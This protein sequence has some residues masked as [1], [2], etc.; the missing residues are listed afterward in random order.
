MPGKR[1][2]TPALVAPLP[3]A[4]RLQLLAGSGAYT[5]AEPLAQSV[6][7]KNLPPPWPRD[8]LPRKSSVTSRI[9]TFCMDHI[10]QLD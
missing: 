4:G 8:E 9:S 2:G 3:L 5:W 10:K 6:A 7:H 1:F